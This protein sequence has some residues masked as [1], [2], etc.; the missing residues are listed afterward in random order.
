MGDRMF[1]AADLEMICWTTER[2]P[3][4][5]QT[6]LA[7]TICENLPWKAP[8]G[9]LK[10]NA[11]LP[12]LEQLAEDGVVRLPVKRE[13]A[14]RRR[15]AFEA[16]PL[17]VVEIVARLA[18]VRPV[19]VEPV[20]KAE[21]AVWD[22]TMAAY[23]GMGFM[24]AFGAHQ[25]YWIRG[26]VADESVILGA[27]LFGAPARIVRVRDQWLGWTALQRQRFRYRIVANNRFLI[28]PGVHVPHLASHAL[29]LALRRLPEDWKGRY[30]YSPVLVET[31]VTPPW[32]GTCYR[33]A[34]WIALGET[35]GQGRQDRR[36]DQGGEVRRVFV[37]P[38]GC[39]WR[40]ALV[41]EQA[42]GK[43]REEENTAMITANQTLNEMA[44]E[45][46]K[47]RYQALAPFLDEKQRRL[48]VGAEALTFGDGGVEQVAALAGVSR[49]TVR[50]GM[51]E[52]QNPDQIEPERVRKLG[53]GRKPKDA[54]DPELRTDLERLV[55]PSTRGDPQS[56]LRW[57]C[58]STRKLA[59]ELNAMKPGRAVSDHLVRELLHEMGYS[60]QANRKTLEGA[61]RPDR[62]AQ[63]Q[64]IND[65]VQ[66][67]QQRG[68]PVISVDTKKKERAP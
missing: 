22:A 49:E 16:E 25:R 46:V 45:R 58:T 15:A 18:E 54:A 48:L 12:L 64:H 7:R 42:T 29:S 3:E 1:T 39:H 53:G 56:P 43:Q 10:V 60:L 28:L 51:R 32:R 36:Y 63:F 30:G 59:G 31:F 33:A 38:L 20:P 2:F 11:C 35:T 67:Y 62:D 52:L 47:Q 8:N 14:P 68:Q 50:R 5:S 19:R 13:R 23:H 44:A 24:Q 65:T 27:L 41:A 4:L 66:D 57:T 55:S 26:E 34:N 40:Q 61:D 17:P 6:E 37:Y 21:Q 9:Q